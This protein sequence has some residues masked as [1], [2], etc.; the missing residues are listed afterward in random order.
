MLT[1]SG[2]WA[3]ISALVQM[4]AWQALSHVSSR[5][6]SGLGAYVC[7]AF[8]YMYIMAMLCVCV[9]VCARACVSMTA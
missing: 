5:E 3:G 9:C 6:S 2:R 7:A 1:N 8:A 4:T